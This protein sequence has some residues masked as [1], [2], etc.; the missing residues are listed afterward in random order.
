MFCKECGAEIPDDSKHCKECGANLSEES[1]K[2]DN[3][4]KKEYPRRL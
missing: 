4:Q 1:S 2:E 3:A